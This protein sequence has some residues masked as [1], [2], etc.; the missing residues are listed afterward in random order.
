MLIIA[1]TCLHESHKFYLFGEN[2]STIVT[3]IRWKNKTRWSDIFFK[4]A[5]KMFSSMG[6]I[7]RSKR[8]VQ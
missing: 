5:I 3:S 4:N 6:I 7:H 1:S 8:C 2:N